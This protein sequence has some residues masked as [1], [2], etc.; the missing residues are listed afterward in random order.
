ME[1]LLNKNVKITGGKYRTEYKTIKDGGGTIVLKQ[2]KQTYSGIDFTPLG[3][4][5]IQRKV[6]NVYIH[7]E[8]QEI[9]MP[10]AQD[11]QVVQDSPDDHVV[12]TS[13]KIEAII[14]EVQEKQVQQVQI[15]EKAGSVADSPPVSPQAK[16][17]S[18]RE[19]ALKEVDPNLPQG[20]DPNIPSME[21]AY[22]NRERLKQKGVE[23]DILKTQVQKQMEHI[24][25]LEKKLCHSTKKIEK[26]LTF[27]YEEF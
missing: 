16:D 14:E 15:T 22:E 4:E 18:A 19:R 27:F 3:G 23:I 5:T 2:P 9:E 12:E 8:I 13:S 25:L 10:S 11:L 24:E 20:V 6:K 26:V 7:E 17:L 21:E 1:N